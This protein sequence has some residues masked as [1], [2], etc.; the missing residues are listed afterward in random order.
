MRPEHTG[1]VWVD[2][3]TT[4]TDA[5]NDRLLEVASIVTDLDGN[6]VGE[7]FSS[8]LFYADYNTTLSLLNENTERMHKDSGLL[9][10]LYFAPGSNS[11]NETD[12]RIAQW[13]EKNRLPQW[14]NLWFGGNSVFLDKEF[15][16]EHLPRF[17]ASISHRSMDMTSVSTFINSTLPQGFP[18]YREHHRH[19]ALPDIQESLDE[20]LYY[21]KHLKNRT[22]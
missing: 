4:G 5:Y 21:R 8:V 12:I 22:I 9:E 3:E 16:R 17:N 19:R 11:P 15:V 6:T 13:L 2:V 10:D 7:P 18:F 14:K 1:I 20:Y